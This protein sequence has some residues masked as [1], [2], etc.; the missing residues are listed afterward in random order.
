MEH[1]I[2]SELEFVRY[3]EQE[4]NRLTPDP[5]GWMTEP[6][7]PEQTLLRLNLRPYKHFRRDI[8]SLVPVL[9]ETARRYCGEVEQLKP[10]WAEFVSA[11]QQGSFA[12]FE[13]GKLDEFTQWV[14]GLGY[15]ALHHSQA[16]TQAYQPAYRLIAAEF[17]P[18]LG[19]ADAS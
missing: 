1:I 17:L 19:L 16:Y 3:L 2:P 15:P 5:D 6:L 13:A 14:E 8:R 7:C 10:A 11:C 18:G 9:M 4:F 12:Q